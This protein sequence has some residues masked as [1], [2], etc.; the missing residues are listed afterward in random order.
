[1]KNGIRIIFMLLICFAAFGS[2]QSQVLFSSKKIKAVFEL[3]PPS[4]QKAAELKQ[5][6]CVWFY[7]DDSLQVNFSYRQNYLTSAGLCVFDSEDE[8]HFPPIVYNFVEM[9]FLKYFL[10][11][12]QATF[13]TANDENKIK[14]Y[15][16]GTELLHN[17][18]IDKSLILSALINSSDKSSSFKDNSYKFVFSKSNYD[19]TLVFPANSLLIQCIDKKEADLALARSLKNFNP[20][21]ALTPLYDTLNLTKNTK[22]I[23]CSNERILHKGVSDQYFMQKTDGEYSPVFEDH[24]YIE[25]LQNEFLVGYADNQ[26]KLRINHH[27]YGNESDHYTMNLNTF[28]QYYRQDK[29]TDFYFGIESDDKKTIVASLFIKH[30]YL[31]S[32]AILTI[33][34]NTTDMFDREATYNC[35]L[36]T[37]IPGDNIKDLFGIYDENASDEFFKINQR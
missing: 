25:S 1:M 11:D 15:L 24:L 29:E 19:L 35:K 34:T 36:Y 17:S 26:K 6:K 22:G 8:K 32:L 28:L 31:N 3:L 13:F 5:S 27:L 20:G 23:F 21:Q 37:N 4:C 12:D 33:M 16:S 30:K 7:Q 14:L 9:F 10:I 18:F 2:I